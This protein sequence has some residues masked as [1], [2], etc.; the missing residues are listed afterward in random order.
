[1]CPAELNLGRHWWTRGW[2]LTRGGRVVP[3]S[4]RN[5]LPSGPLLVAADMKRIEDLFRSHFLMYELRGPDNKQHV[6]LFTE[7]LEPVSD[8]DHGD[9]PHSWS[10]EAELALQ[11]WRNLTEALQP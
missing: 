8:P 9:L 11:G 4:W 2:S 1:M 6:W 3:Y 10:I 7:T 5:Y